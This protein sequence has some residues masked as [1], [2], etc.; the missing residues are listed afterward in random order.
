MS[1]SNCPMFTESSSSR[2]TTTD[3]DTHISIP[4]LRQ[5]DQVYS[6]P[7]LYTRRF[8]NT[9]CGVPVGQRRESHSGTTL[10]W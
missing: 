6:V 5:V 10:Q 1:S 8:H 7:N 4:P 2:W 9:D 3:W